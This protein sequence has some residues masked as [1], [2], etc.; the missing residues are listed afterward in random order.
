MIGNIPITD[1]QS[2]YFSSSQNPEPVCKCSLSLAVKMKL[3]HDGNVTFN[4]TLMV[5]FTSLIRLSYYICEM[6][7]NIAYCILYCSTCQHSSLS[8]QVLS[9]YIHWVTV[10]LQ[11]S[12]SQNSIAMEPVFPSILN[13]ASIQQKSYER[14]M[15]LA[16]WP[17]I[18]QWL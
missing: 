1:L 14:L 3:V 5:T 4:V 8:L 13:Q 11:H 6:C 16:L 2:G 12:T 17:P 9:C 15:N 18:L 10:L 7:S